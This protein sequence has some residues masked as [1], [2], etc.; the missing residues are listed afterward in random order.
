MEVVLCLFVEQVVGGLGKGWKQGGRRA[1]ELE[2]AAAAASAAGAAAAASTVAAT[3]SYIDPSYSCHCPRS[4][5][6]NSRILKT[7]L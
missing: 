5:R 4:C 7:I 2:A 6:K 1:V 3:Q